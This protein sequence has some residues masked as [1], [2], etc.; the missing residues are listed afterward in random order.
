MHWPSYSYQA[1][2]FPLTIV[3]SLL[4]AALLLFFKLRRR[5]A[6]LDGAQHMA[7]FDRKTKWDYLMRKYILAVC[8]K[9]FVLS[10]SVKSGKRSRR[11]GSAPTSW[12]LRRTGSLR[13]RL[14]GRRRRY[15]QAVRHSERSLS[16]PVRRANH[17]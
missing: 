17:P 3:K 8:N 16:V 12:S 1:S 13:G 15:P 4:Y 9:G 14:S 6:F 2:S 11:S 10:E 7:A 5:S